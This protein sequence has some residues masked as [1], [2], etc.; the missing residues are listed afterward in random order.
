[1]RF[2]LKEKFKATD[3]AE[4]LKTKGKRAEHILNI[5]RAIVDDQQTEL[6][7]IRKRVKSLD[8][9]MPEY[10]PSICKRLIN[11]FCGRWTGNA[12]N[13]FHS[14]KRKSTTM[15]E[16]LDKRLEEMQKLQYVYEMLVEK[17]KDKIVRLHEKVDLINEELLRLN[18]HPLMAKELVKVLNKTSGVVNS[19]NVKNLLPC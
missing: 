5:F 12:E 1:M 18:N 8:E 13:I 14:Q 9:T 6:G 17:I 11:F 3:E 2:L 7:I 4:E 10:E 19:S 16:T 15:A